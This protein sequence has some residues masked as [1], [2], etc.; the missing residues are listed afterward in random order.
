MGIQ[1]WMFDAVPACYKPPKF[2]I[3]LLSWKN[4]LIKMYGP[5]DACLEYFFSEQQGTRI[6]LT[7][8]RNQE[9]AWSLILMS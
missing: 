2:M 9:E 8:P 7:L 3:Y 1:E 6:W 4:A 5:P